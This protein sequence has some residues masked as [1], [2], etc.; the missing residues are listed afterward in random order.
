MCYFVE[1]LGDTGS[2][3]ADKEMVLRYELKKFL[4]LLKTVVVFVCVSLSL[5][6]V[7]LT[8]SVACFPNGGLML[9]LKE[10]LMLGGAALTSLGLWEKSSS[11]KMLVSCRK[12]C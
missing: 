7:I 9:L 2:E 4:F 3:A 12:W 6:L 5:S 8:R 10:E 11:V 1:G